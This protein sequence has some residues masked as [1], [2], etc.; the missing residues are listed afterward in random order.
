MSFQYNHLFLFFIQIDEI[1]HLNK[2]LHFFK[3]DRRK[4][5]IDF[6]YIEKKIIV[7]FSGDMPILK[8]S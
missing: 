8:N 4:S 5:S 7:I 1:K 6:F 2:N 3:Y